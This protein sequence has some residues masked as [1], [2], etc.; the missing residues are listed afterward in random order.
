[1]LKRVLAIALITLS[2]GCASGKSN[3]ALDVSAVVASFDPYVGVPQRFI[4][5]LISGDGKNLAYG[6]VEL[7]FRELDASGD[8]PTINAEFLPVEGEAKRSEEPRLVNPSEALGTYGGEVTFDSSGN[9]EVRVTG[10]TKEGELDASAQFVVSESPRILAPGEQAPR[11]VQPLAP[12]AGVDP[13]SIDSRATNG[14]MPDPELHNITIADAI[15]SGK[16]TMVV[17]TTPMYCTSRFCGPI[18]D[19]VAELAEKYSDQMNFV[20]LEVWQD[21]ANNVPN[22]AAL[23]WITPRNGGDPQEPWVFVIN[24]SGV[25]TQRFDNAATVNELQ[26]AAEEALG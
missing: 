20:H 26:R 22:P 3:E 14:E 18:T 25:I 9:W 24:G 4:V 21:Y 1:M 12:A 16:P 7:S 17:V 15:A 10:E 6:D 8:A 2:T 23:E 5:G 19:N 11:T 13:K